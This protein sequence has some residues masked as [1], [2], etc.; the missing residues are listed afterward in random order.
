MNINHKFYILFVILFLGL[1]SCAINSGN[2][3]AGGFRWKVPFFGSDS[4]P[5]IYNE[6][7]YI[8]SLRGDIYAINPNN[9]K[10]IWQFQTGEVS[11]TPLIEDGVVYVGSKDQRFYALDAQSGKLKWATDIY[12]P[13]F[14]KAT[15][16][17][18]NIIV[19]G[20]GMGLSPSA[21]YV[22]SKVSG[23][24]AW[25]TEGKG[26][27][28]DPYF[29][30]GTLYYA[31]SEE[32]Y[33][34]KHFSFFMYSVEENTGDVIWTLK[35]Q[36]HRPRKVY[37]SENL[38]Y[39]SAFKSEGM[40]PNARNNGFYELTAA[41]VYAINASTG[42]L[43]WEYKGGHVG[44]LSPRLMV[45]SKNIYLT[46]NEGFYALDKST[47]KLNW[48][49]EGSFSTNFLVENDFLYVRGNNHIYAVNPQSGKIIWGYQDANLFHTKLIGNTVYVS[50]Q[51]SQVAL[52]A[53]TGELLWKFQ[54]RKR[55]VRSIGV[56]APPLIF[57]NHAIFPTYT[58]R[59]LAQG[60]LY[61]ISLDRNI[62]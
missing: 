27:A 46:S 47:G 9:G 41:Y 23:K 10:Q 55:N 2:I 62:K 53:T 43:V 6:T 19:H 18:N 59:H 61:S 25:S 16:S 17:K 13:V 56:T 26:S 40:V 1:P 8:G 58:D 28:T 7:V 15:F 22:L 35:L 33:P 36:G 37:G 45:G 20:I 49:L 24:I 44:Y 50:A 5:V 42:K 60:Y 3:E 12:H 31:L 29:K 14:D 32:E 52:N 38:I 21:V 39:V 30:D 51:Q 57:E 11:A 4:E 34:L 54:I 48:F